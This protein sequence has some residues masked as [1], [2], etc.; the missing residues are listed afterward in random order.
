MEF[1]KRQGNCLRRKEELEEK[2]M[3]IEVVDGGKEEKMSGSEKNKTHIDKATTQTDTELTET[4]RQVNRHTQLS[5]NQS[6]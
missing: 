4:D 6:N 5:S 2:E 3:K 1:K